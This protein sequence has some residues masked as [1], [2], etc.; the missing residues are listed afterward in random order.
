[1]IISHRRHQAF[2]KYILDQ[3][4]GH[5]SLQGLPPFG[6]VPRSADSV[7]GNMA[8]GSSGKIVVVEGR[9]TPPRFV[10]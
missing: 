6:L 3:L 9:G 1:M 2:C 8:S 7:L 5:A 4:F 10:L